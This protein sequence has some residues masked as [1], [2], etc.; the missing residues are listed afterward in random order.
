MSTTHP[1]PLDDPASLGRALDDLLVTRPA[2]LALG[3]PTHGIEAF[4]RLRN[5]VLAHLVDRGFRSIAL[6]T[7]AFAAAL[8]DDYTAGGNYDVDTLDVDTVLAQGFSHGFG[9]V[10]GNRELLD[11]LREH[12][13]G[14]APEDRVRFHGFDAP[15]ESSGAPSPRTALTRAVEHLP[16][17]LRPPSTCDL[18]ALLGE[19]E[20][21]TN[22]AAMYDPTASI[23][24]SERVRSL[25]VAADDVVS[26]LRRASPALRQAD[27]TGFDLAVAHARTARGLLRY[28]A[29][30]AR[31]TPDRIGTL[32]SLR[33]EM[34]ADNLL[35]IVEQEQQRG[36][37]LVFAHNAHLNRALSRIPVGGQDVSWA[38]AGALVALTLG[39]RYAVVVTDSNPNSEPGTLQGEMAA[40][41]RTRSLFQGGALPSGAAGKPILPGHIPLT[42][43]D[44]A[45]ADAVIFVADT[46]GTRHQYW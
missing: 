12:N 35:S 42:P 25:H 40:Q 9:N 19:D 43:D 14:R 39:S 2:L 46:D 8:V 38:S 3:E 1:V 21:W 13:A 7:D 30:M 4:P 18:D 20:P 28:H 5:D 45:A 37:T 29:A 34:M 15:L 33:A 44:L 31:D 27:P 22:P 32:L 10:P 24:G 6:E 26:A 41:T 16:E 11:W 23:G 17:A 36:P